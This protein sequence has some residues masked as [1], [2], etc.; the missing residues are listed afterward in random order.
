MVTSLEIPD[1]TFLS[2]VFLSHG[3]DFQFRTI[4]GTFG[5]L[6]GSTVLYPDETDLFEAVLELFYKRVD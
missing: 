4:S 1:V 2:S 3:A 6:D 5:K